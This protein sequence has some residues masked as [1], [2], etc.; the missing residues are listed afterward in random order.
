LLPECL[1]DFIDE[2]NPVRAVDAFV[3]ALNLGKLGFDGV[4]CPSSYALRQS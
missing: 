2:S 4:D 3:D 1:D